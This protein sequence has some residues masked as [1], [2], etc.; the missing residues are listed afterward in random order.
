MM[1]RTKSYILIPKCS[2]KDVDN[3]PNMDYNVL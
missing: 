2:K 3:P 1:Y